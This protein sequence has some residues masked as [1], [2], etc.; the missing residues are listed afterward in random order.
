MEPTLS[1]LTALFAAWLRDIDSEPF[2]YEHEWATPDSMRFRV[3]PTWAPQPRGPQPCDATQTVHD[4]FTQ[5][6][7]LE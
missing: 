1:Q 4:L 7:A 6:G 3:E 5:P 2:A